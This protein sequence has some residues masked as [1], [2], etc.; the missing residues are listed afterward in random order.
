VLQTLVKITIS[1]SVTFYWFPQ[2]FSS[3]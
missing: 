2:Y 3:L 1:L